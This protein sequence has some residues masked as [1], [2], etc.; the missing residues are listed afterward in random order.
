M[1][2]SAAHDARNQLLR[3]TLSNNEDARKSSVP[4]GETVRRITSDLGISLKSENI[5]SSDGARLH[6]IGQISAEK[7]LL[8]FHGGGFGLSAFEGHIKFLIQSQEM[9]AAQASTV[10]I[11]FLEY[12]LTKEKKY[13]T[14][15]MQATEALRFLLSK[16]FRSSN[17]VV[18]GDSAG[19]NMTLGLASVLMHSCT[20]VTPLQI[21]EPLAGLLLISPWVSFESSSSSYR[22]NKEYDIF[23]SESMQGWATDFVLDQERNNWNEPIKADVAWWQGLQAEKVLNVYGS[24]EVLQE[25]DKILGDTLHKA[26]VAVKNV[27]CKNQVHIDCILDAQFGLEVGPMST[28]IWQWL[29]TVFQRGI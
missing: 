3:E 8:Y 26:G 18:G 20:G 5:P 14:Q 19:G 25:D 17:I 29:A 13:P 2:R 28:E 27:E 10:L 7:V 24:L 6:F 9:L 1:S 16:G 15:L 21:Q 23:G 11:A 4:T 22:R 12:G